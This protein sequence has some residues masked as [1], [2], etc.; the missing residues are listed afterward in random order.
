MNQVCVACETINCTVGIDQNRPHRTCN[1]RIG[2]SSWHRRRAPVGRIDPVVGARTAVPNRLASQRRITEH[3]A[4][5]QVIGCGQIGSTS[6]CRCAR[7][8]CA[9]GQHRHVIGHGCQVT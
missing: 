3:Q 9:S 4:L 5:G 1:V 7:Q 2:G 8:T 6:Q